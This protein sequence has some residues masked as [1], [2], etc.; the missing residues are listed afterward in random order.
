MKMWRYWEIVLLL[1]F[2][3]QVSSLNDTIHAEN[4]CIWYDQCKQVNGNWLNCYNNTPSVLLDD[5]SIEYN[6]LKDVCP[7]YISSKPNSTRVC[8][9]LGQMNALKSS[10]LKLAQQLLGRCP[11]CYR[12]FM[13]IFCATTCNPSNSLFMNVRNES[14]DFNTSIGRPPAIKTVDV[15]F[16][17]DYTDKFFNSCKDVQFAQESSK[18]ISLMCGSNDPCT[19]PKWLEFMGTPMPG[20]P[21]PFQLNFTFTDYSSGGIIPKNMTA[22]DSKLIGCDERYQGLTCSCSDCPAVCPATPTIPPDKGSTKVTFIPL[23]IFVGVIGF[24]IYNI[25]FMICVMTYL[26]LQLCRDTDKKGYELIGI[27]DTSFCLTDIG[28]RCEHFISKLFSVWGYI[29]ATFW[30]LVVPVALLLLAACCVGLMFFEVT[31]DPVELWSSPSSRARKEKEYF[32]QHF[33]PFYR[34]AQI[35]ITAPH[36]S[37]F[38][39]PDSQNYKM[40]YHF[41]GVFQQDVLN[42]IWHMQDDIIHLEVPFNKTNGT[43]NY[44]SLKDICFQPLSPDNLNCTVYSVLN[45]FQNDYDKLNKHVTPVFTDSANSSTHIHY[46]AR[47][48][49][50]LNATGLNIP[51]MAEYGGPVDPSVALGGYDMVNGSA[52]YDMARAIIITFVIN[53]HNE[54]EK[55]K[56]A[57]KWEEAFINYMKSYKEKVHNSALKFSFS[58]ESSIPSELER[59]SLADVRTIII[60][61][62]LMFLYI[63]LFLGSFARRVIR[64]LYNLFSSDHQRFDFGMLTNSRIGLGLLGV[65]LV[66]LSVVAAIGLLSYLRIKATLIIIEVVPFLVLAVGTDNL[67]ILTHAFERKQRSKPGAPVNLLI[68]DALGEVAPSILLTSLT[69][70]AAFLLGGISTMPAVRT[71]SFFAGTAV[72]INFLLQISVFT[73][74]LG[75]DSKRIA[76][77]RPDLICC[78]RLPKNEDDDEENHES[79]LFL[80]MSN[81]YAPFILHKYIRML[82]MYIFSALFFGMLVGVFHEDIGLSQSIALPKDSYLQDYFDDL[83]TYLHTGPPVYFVIKEG[84]NYSIEANQNKICSTAGCNQDSMGVQI[85]SASLI[86]EYS[87]I[88]EHASIWLDSYFAWSDPRSGCCKVYKNRTASDETRCAAGTNKSICDDCLVKDVNNNRPNSSEFMR[89]LPWFLTSNPDTTTCNQGGHAAFSSAVNVSKNNSHVIASYLMTYHTIL[90]DSSD[91]INALERAREYSDD[92]SHTLGHEVFA[93]SVFYVFYEQYLTIKID[94][95][96]NLCISLAAVFVMSFL[97][98]GFNIISALIVTA[99]VALIIVDMLGMMAW[100]GISLNAISLVNLVMAVGISVEFCSHIVRWFAHSPYHSRL[101]RAKDAITHMGTSVLSGITFT[102][103]LGVSVLVFAKSQIFVEFYFAMYMLMIAF[104]A[105]HGLVFLP[106]LLSYIGPGVPLTD[107]DSLHSSSNHS[108]NEDA[109][110]YEPVRPRSR[111]SSRSSAG[112]YPRLVGS[113]ELGRPTENTKL[114]NA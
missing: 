30:F 78:V 62:I 64:T 59:E 93:Y 105:L 65:I 61:Y 8:C 75:L 14:L 40:I 97:L 90:R 74:V 76:S 98:M 45:Y 47:D 56:P 70:T 111:S 11:S 77:N 50:S 96:I 58:S 20:S 42:E 32:D 108:L 91:F 89:Y 95:A 12:N 15:Y 112:T 51:C 92:F 34:T 82:V 55:N 7:W 94:V 28:R 72:F 67:F 71:F 6:T 106:V 41:S 38:S 87:K 83:S 100:V 46:C 39:F 36:S 113:V 29:A 44:V 80:F 103:F 2:A 48:P 109:V 23:G 110:N 66:A 27:A 31:T 26:V 104:G 63:A 35:I 3:G 53:N 114:V 21:A 13:D 16:T 102:K 10:S 107:I 4:T 54:K 79:S 86:S 17:N 37:D 99:T 24:V 5:N 19:G 52:Q 25:I 49:S 60:S 18:V 69:E 57:E 85:S 1:Y 33:G 22:R 43:V 84:Y 88:S 9:N 101:E 81:C 68:G 73:A